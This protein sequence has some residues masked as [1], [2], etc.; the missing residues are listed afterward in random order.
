M[1]PLVDTAHGVG[2]ET[3][4]AEPWLGLENNASATGR[5]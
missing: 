3:P 4:L 5:R 1:I 2:A